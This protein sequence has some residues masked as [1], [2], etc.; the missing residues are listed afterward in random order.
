[1]A[2]WLLRATSQPFNP[3]ATTV[4]STD[5]RAQL[6]SI[7]IALRDINEP[8]VLS[9]LS[10]AAGGDATA[11]EIDDQ[12]RMWRAGHGVGNAKSPAAAPAPSDFAA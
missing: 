9:L 1:M 8:A 10:R 12:G 4:C 6:Q 5:E 2:E 3:H 7:R 11:Y